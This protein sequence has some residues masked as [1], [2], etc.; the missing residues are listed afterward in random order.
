MQLEKWEPF[1][2]LATLQD[3]MNRLFGQI[4]G[5]APAGR[6]V[7]EGIWAPLV[8]V[9]ETKDQFVVK[10]ELPGMTKDDIKISVIGNE[11]AISGE[12]KQEEIAEEKTYHRIERSYG[13]FRRSLSL[14]T[15]IESSKVT[16][17]YVDGVLE[18]VLPK[19]E[20]VKPREVSISVK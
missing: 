3:E 14:P 1:R 9:E 17:R 19:S 8:D 11:L 15:D 6:A 7:S 4:F 5:R 16:A 13:R 2:E 20:Q 12:R 18:V 10:V